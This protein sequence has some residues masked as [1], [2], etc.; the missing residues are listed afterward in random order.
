MDGLESPASQRD[1]AAEFGEQIQLAARL[2]QGFLPRRLPEVGLARFGVLFRP[3]GW[4]SGDFYD[5]TRL[6]ETHVGFYVVDAV[7]HG[8]PAALLTMFIKRALKTKRIAGNTYQ[9]VPPHIAL[10]E[11]NADICDQDLASCS[12]CTAVY[13]MLDV[14]NH[15]LTYARAGHPAPILIRSGGQIE[16]LEV[17]G[18]LLGV[19]PDAE[20]TSHTCQLD[21]GDRLIL[22]TDGVDQVFAFA[23]DTPPTSAAFLERLQAWSS[24]S[25]PEL[26]LEMAG[27][28]NAVGEIEPHMDDVTV[29]VMDLEHP[30]TAGPW[31]A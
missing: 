20:F 16:T 10:A 24:F 25:R 18:G 23:D 9:I 17:S 30:S 31:A 12:F 13:C 3:A 14:A 1:P 29:L 7:G 15:T 19:F 26:L 27:L 28:T 6:D 11:L 8:L 2:Q 5:I 21:P 4:L 22:H